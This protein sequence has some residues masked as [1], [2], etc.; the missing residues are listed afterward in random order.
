MIGHRGGAALA[1]P[2]LYWRGNFKKGVYK[3]HA[4]VYNDNV[5]SVN[6]K[7]PDGTGK[8]ALPW[9]KVAHGKV[10]DVHPEDAAGNTVSAD[11][12]PR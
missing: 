11:V 8:R 12:Y 1:A 2:L 4:L 9:L 3:P 6:G 5:K 7:R 10:G